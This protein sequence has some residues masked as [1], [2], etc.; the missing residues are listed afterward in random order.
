[1]NFPEQI[2]IGEGISAIS[3]F[4]LN[5]QGNFANP[6]DE[7]LLC[8]LSNI[9]TSLSLVEKDIDNILSILRGEMTFADEYA[10]MMLCISEN[11]VPSQWLRLTTANM[12][13]TIAFGEWRQNL[14]AKVDYFNEW[15]TTGSVNIYHLP[16]FSNTK[17]FFANL[18]MFFCRR[19][20]DIT[21]DSVNLQFEITNAKTANE[22]PKEEEANNEEDKAA[23][24]TKQNNKV[25]I[26][27]IE[28]INA[29]YDGVL[30]MI[31]DNIYNDMPIM[32][33]ICGKEKEKK[34][35]EKLKKDDIVIEEEDSEEDDKNNNKDEENEE[36]IFKEEQSFKDEGC[37]LIPL[38]ENKYKRNDVDNDNPLSMIEIAYN[39]KYNEEKFIIKGVKMFIKDE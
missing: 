20:T 10:N 30:N 34:E 23:N 31:E 25:Y 5:K 28:I 16:Y 14:K 27:G 37:L 11:K 33:V 3:L 13:S 7:S 4:K 6:L 39:Q 21:P 8:E 36:P 22:L 15:V 29:E 17:L 18:R 19:N 12:Q 2:R 35:E 1:M 9:N 32:E 24:V 26:S 38:Y